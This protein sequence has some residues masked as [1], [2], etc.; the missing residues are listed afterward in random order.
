MPINWFLINSF[1]NI[2]HLILVRMVSSCL[3]VGYYIQYDW[4]LI[5]FPLTDTDMVIIYLSSGVTSRDSSEREKRATLSVVKEENRHLNNS[6]MIL[7]YALMNGEI[8]TRRAAFLLTLC[9]AGHEGS[10]W[11]PVCMF[12]LFQNMFS[13]FDAPSSFFWSL[14][15]GP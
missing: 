3:E 12:V 1:R 11:T 4:L 10:C 8:Q 9:L 6:V 5:I 14:C 13:C 2:I 15:V 7:T